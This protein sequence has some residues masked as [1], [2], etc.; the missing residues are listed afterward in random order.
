MI[1]VRLDNKMQRSEFR[2][3]L[4]L[5]QSFEQVEVLVVSDEVVRGVDQLVRG[6]EFGKAS[7]L[8]IA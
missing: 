1:K 7:H 5:C 2:L 6:L 4:R 3:L 8:V